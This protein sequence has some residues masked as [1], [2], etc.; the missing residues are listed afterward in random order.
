MHPRPRRAGKWTGV[1]VAASREDWFGDVVD[2]DVIF[3]LCTAIDVGGGYWAVV[4][5]AMLDV[6]RR[7]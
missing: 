6:I 5:C 3:G 2:A 1:A 4:S 7:R